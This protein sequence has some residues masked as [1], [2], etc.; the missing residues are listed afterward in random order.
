MNKKTEMTIMLSTMDDYP[1]HQITD[2][3]AHTDTSDRNFYDRYYFNLMN[4]TEDIFVVFGL[5]QY[6]NLGTQDGFVLVRHG[7]KHHV[8]RASRELGDRADIS[9]GPMRIEILEGLKKLRIIVEDN[10]HGIHLD[11]VWNGIHKPFLEPRHY[12]RKK[13]RVLFDTLRFAQMGTW[14]GQLTVGDKTWNIT[15]EQWFGSRDRSWGVRPIGEPEPQGIQTGSTSM[16]GMWN[17]FPVLFDDFVLLYIL[18]ENNDGTR[19]IEESMRVWKDESREMEWLG[20]PEHHHVFEQAAP[21]KAHIKEGVIRFPDAPGGVL[22]LR[23][24][25]L[26]QTYLTAGTGYGLEADWRHGMYQGPLKVQGFTWDAVSDADKMWGLIETP[27]RFTLGDKIGYG[28][29]EF[30]FFSAF[31]KYTA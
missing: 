18:N 1:L 25:P 8:L 3:M 13:G 9:V 4:G 19:T 28:M 17:Y 11:V 21:Y 14:E 6:P 30:A 5:G 12:I 2:V 15:P 10:E 23:G 26:L 27:A 7:N 29:M 20:K 24:T 31:D 16:E 22:E